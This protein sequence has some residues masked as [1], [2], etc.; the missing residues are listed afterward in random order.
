MHDSKKYKKREEVCIG[1]MIYYQ[2]Y[3]LYYDFLAKKMTQM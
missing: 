1:Q 2:K 3:E